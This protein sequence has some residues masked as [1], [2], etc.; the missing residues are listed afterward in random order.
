MI[1]RKRGDGKQTSS[2]C[3]NK[4]EL[5]NSE[6]QLKQMIFTLIAPLG[7]Q[8]SAFARVRRLSFISILKYGKS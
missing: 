7:K 3:G 6:E 8:L 1:N 4:K 2:D 5:L